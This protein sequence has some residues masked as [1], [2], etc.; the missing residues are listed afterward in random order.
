MKRDIKAPS[1][2][3]SI[4]EVRILRWAKKNGESVK[5]NDLLLE[6]ESDKATVEVVAEYAGALQVI[7]PEGA[8]VQVGSIIGA[9]EEGAAGT[10]SASAPS[11]TVSAAAAPTPAKP[12]GAT[13]ASD[14][15]LSPAVRKLVSE[16]QVDTAAVSGSGLGGR[17]TKGDVLQHLET[18]GS[19]PAPAPASAPAAS[20]APSSPAAA[21]RNLD[22][23]DRRQPMSLLRKKIAERLV[24]AQHTAAILTTFNEVDM[25]AVNAVRAQHKDAFKAKH[26]VSLGYMSFFSRAVCEAMKAVPMVNGSIDGSDIISRDYIDLGIAIGSPRGLVVPVLRDAHQ[27]GFVDIEKSIGAFANKAKEGKLTIKELSGG[28]F[29]ISNGGTYGSLLS[30][31]IL[32]PPQTAILGMHKIE[33][34]PIA[35]N[36]QVVIRPMMYVALSYDHRLIDGKEAVTFLVKM[37]EALENPSVLNLSY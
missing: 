29:T 13:A 30:T 34:R 7:Q 3:E 2:G 16:N 6:I 25:S 4:T 1:V 22:P 10:V 5:V 15:P 37:K 19:A 18:R 17:L 26:G 12:H 32:T 31:P 9:I 21:P 8:T 24:S 23:R 33:E 11:S 27:M 28:T 14:T 36:G 20:H 35:L